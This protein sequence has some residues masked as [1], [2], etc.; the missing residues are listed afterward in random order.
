MVILIIM[1]LSGFEDRVYYAGDSYLICTVVILSV[2]EI[3]LDTD[4]K[5]AKIEV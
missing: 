1:G 2:V 4:A 5:M 3:Y